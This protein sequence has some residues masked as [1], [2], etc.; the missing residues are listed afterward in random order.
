[1]TDRNSQGLWSSHGS[2]LRF[3][4]SPR[5]WAGLQP[6]VDRGEEERYLEAKRD[7][8]EGRMYVGAQCSSEHLYKGESFN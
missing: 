7:G 4:W 2:K 8:V 5:V 6:G 3:S 1:M